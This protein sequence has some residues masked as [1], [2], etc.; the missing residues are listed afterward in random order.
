MPI[1]VS[2]IKISPDDSKELAFEKAFKVLRLKASQVREASIS[3][4][5]VDAR[6]NDRVLLVCSVAVTCDNEEKIAAS[7]KSKN[8]VLR[9]IAPAEIPVLKKVPETKPVI[10]GFGPAGMFAGLYLARAGACPI[11]FERYISLAS[12]CFILS[13]DT[14]FS[15]AFSFGSPG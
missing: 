12:A 2:E 4:I 14:A 6:H 15:K 1:I 3:K 10:I 5:S 13:T 9:K 7:A 8:V 11:I